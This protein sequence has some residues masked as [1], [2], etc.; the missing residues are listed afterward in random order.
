MRIINI[1]NKSMLLIAITMTIA[2]KKEKVNDEK[3]AIEI[4]P[5]EVVIPPEQAISD[6]N[7]R[8]VKIQKGNLKMTFTYTDT[9]L[10]K[11]DYSDG[12]TIILEL[13]EDH[14]P[15]RLQTYAGTTLI[16]TSEYELGTDGRVEKSDQY[17]TKGK[18]TTLSGHTTMEYNTAKRLIAVRQYNNGNELLDERKWTYDDTG[19]LVKAT[20]SKI[21]QVLAYVYDTKFGLF[22][23]ARYAYL[24]YLE[25]ND[26]LY[27]SVVNN[28]KGISGAVM[29]SDNLNFDFRYNQ[30]D[31]PEKIMLK[32]AE[33]PVSTY[34]ILYQ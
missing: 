5:P 33:Q 27:L 20:S 34:E 24:F 8:P 25:N 6:N 17:I 18:K 29:P 22:K 15:A 11:I 16:N 7:S 3:T 4:T 12:K 9:L 10:T 26:P 30:Q 23:H 32:A 21:S 2:C 28:L 19:R 13:N 14:L 31:Y 1:C